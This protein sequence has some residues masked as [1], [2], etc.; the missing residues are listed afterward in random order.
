VTV[1]VATAGS[2]PPERSVP[3]MPAAARVAT[4]AAAG[5]PAL[6]SVVARSTPPAWPSASGIAVVGAAA[7]AVTHGFADGSASRGPDLRSHPEAPGTYTGRN[8]MWIPELG[9][10]RP[11]HLFPCTRKREP[12]NLMYRWG[13]AGSNN[14][15][16]LGHAYGVMKPL[17]DAYNAGRLRVGMLALYADGGGRIRVY[18]VTEWRVVDPVDSAWAIASQPVRSMTLQT[19]VGP[20]GVLRLNVR[21]IEVPL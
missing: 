4:F 9:I 3:S 21:L 20:N 1:G 6:T 13:C 12:D 14:V 11:V 19:C 5:G 17:H 18:A 2:A 15:Y 16:L 10:S 7:A 8:H